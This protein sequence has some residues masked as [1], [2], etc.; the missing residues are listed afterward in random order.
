MQGPL[1]RLVAVSRDL[2]TLSRKGRGKEARVARMKRSEIR[3]QF[4]VPHCASPH[5]GYR[6]DWFVAFAP[7]NDAGGDAVRGRLVIASERGV[8]ASEA[9]QSIDAEM[10]TKAYG[11]LRRLGSPQ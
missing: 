9:K 6:L 10:S 5:A 3:D 11:L 8:I 4:A 1:T 7:R 2:A